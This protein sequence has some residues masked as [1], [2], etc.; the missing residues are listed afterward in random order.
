MTDEQLEV[1]NSALDY[2]KSAFPEASP[3]EFRRGFIENL[4][5]PDNSVD[6]IISNCVI[7]LTSDK[8]KAFSEIYRILKENGE[9]CFSD[10]FSDRPLPQAARENKVLVSECIGNALD[11]STF[12]S[13]MK[14]VGFD[15]IWPVEARKVPIE[16][17]PSEIIPQGTT[18]FSITFSAYKL[19][20]RI[21][22]WE[23]D[24]A[25]YI[26]GIP[27]CDTEWR[28]DLNHTFKKGVEVPVCSKLGI[29]LKARY[30]K[31]FELK[32]MTNVPET[33]KS[34]SFI[35]TVCEVCETRL[36]G[37]ASGCCRCCPG[38]CC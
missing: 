19:K 4:D 17:V 35:D 21:C 22:R 5:F 38:D 32:R 27:E 9:I 37:S 26:G 18:F 30:G 11:L 31:H 6:V 36:P 12:V 14:D 15:D 34:R 16:G 29:I 20:D 25:T 1:A 10:I 2:H 8:K 23:G 3:V 13:I 28:F 24:V 33:E 7:N